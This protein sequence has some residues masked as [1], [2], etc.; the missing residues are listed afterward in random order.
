MIDILEIIESVEK[1]GEIKAKKVDLMEI[2][3]AVERSGPGAPIPKAVLGKVIGDA[4]ARPTCAVNRE[5]EECAATKPVSSRQSWSAVGIYCW[6]MSEGPQLTTKRDL[7]KENLPEDWFEQHVRSISSSVLDR[8]HADSI[9]KF[10]S[11]RSDA[12]AGEPLPLLEAK[13]IVKI[14][15]RRL[16]EPETATQE[17][18]FLRTAIRRGMEYIEAWDQVR[19]INRKASE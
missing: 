6:Q 16:G 2:I 12:D 17:K 3:E 5:E 7:T 13:R 10:R 14:L 8:F 11:A 15:E 1:A 19:K 18:A 9:R 4:V